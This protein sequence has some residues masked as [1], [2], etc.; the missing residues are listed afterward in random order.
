MPAR[1]DPSGMESSSAQ[2]AAIV[3]KLRSA[4]LS[5]RR[6]FLRR[7]AAAGAGA[8]ALAVGSSNAVRAHDPGGDDADVLNFALTLEHLEYAFYR[9]GLDRFDVKDFRKAKT[10][11]GFSNRI[12]SDVRPNLVDV[13]EHEETHVPR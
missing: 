13:R 12:K 5:S 3:S 8:L 4:D 9:D 10:L 1:A 11:Q 7:S 2:D 6:S